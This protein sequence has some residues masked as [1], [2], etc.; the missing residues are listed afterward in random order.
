VP[1]RDATPEQAKPN[2]LASTVT[3]NDSAESFKLL[4]ES[5]ELHASQLDE[6]IKALQKIQAKILEDQD[7]I[8]EQVASLNTTNQALFTQQKASFELMEQ[9]RGELRLLSES[10]AN[11]RRL[12]TNSTAALASLSSLNLSLD[13]IS[14]QPQSG[15]WSI[16][17]DSALFD[18]D[19]H[20]KIGSKSL[21]ESLAKSL[22][23]SQKKIRVQVVGYAD[24]EP[25]TWPWSKPMND[26]ELG[27]LR[28]DRVKAILVRMSL[29]PSNALSSTHGTYADLPHPGESLHNRTV[30]LN[31]FLQ[32]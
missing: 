4:K 2:E 11:D 16:R 9:T 6:Q 7:K 8:T 28:A 21:I 12:V 5:L 30:V 23:R 18:R 14:V 19:D 25:P 29:F 27:Q 13:G 20:L 3:A 10:Y 26:A 24:N 31:I 32:P 1:T 17:F 22:V 15:G